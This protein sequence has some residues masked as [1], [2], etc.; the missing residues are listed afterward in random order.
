[1]NNFAKPQSPQVS[2][3][4]QSPQIQENRSQALPQNQVS[5]GQASQGQS[6]Q[7]QLTMKDEII[8]LKKRLMM[9]EEKFN[10]L[11]QRFE[12]LEKKSETSPPIHANGYAAYSMPLPTISK[13]PLDIKGIISQNKRN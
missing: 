11:E 3:R 8:R 12:N 7:T 4:V 9:V 13:E 10:I 1:M 5:Q 6:P 2:S